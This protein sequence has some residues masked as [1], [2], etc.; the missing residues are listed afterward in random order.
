MVTE[1][2]SSPKLSST[3][4]KYGFNIALHQSGENPAY[5]LH[6]HDYCEFVIYLGSSPGTYQVNGENYPISFG[7][8]VVCDVL[9]EHIFLF[10][11]NCQHMRFSVGLSLS[12]ILAC[13]AGKDNLL[14]IFSHNS[15]SYPVLHIGAVEIYRYLN[16]INAV[17][18]CA[19]KHG[20][21]VYK[22]AILHQMLAFLYD[23]FLRVNNGA[24]VNAPQDCLVRKLIDLINL[25]LGED[26]SLKVLAHETHY[27]AAYLC[28]VFKE[29]THG[30]LT[31]YIAKKRINM[32]A[33]LMGSG[34]S[35]SE[36]SMQVGFQ[37]YSSFYKTFKKITG[38]G[39]NEYYQAHFGKETAA[40]EIG[41]TGKIFTAI[42]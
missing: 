31:S 15:T 40:S 34:C 8:I 20:Q 4:D 23:D 30:T 28:R 9:D 1:R 26:L 39:P 22:Q 11:H 25:H 32:A 37:N 2:R 19:L 10:E 7:D 33:L 18:S 6:Y 14:Q 29:I 5:F 13:S 27:N 42:P 35:L 12:F 38:I 3:V 17:Q 24:V 41:E 16:L 21:T 36:I